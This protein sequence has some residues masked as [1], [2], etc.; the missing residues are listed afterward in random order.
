VFGLLTFTTFGTWLPGPA[1]GWIDAG[2]A[3]TGH[4]WPEPNEAISAVRRRSLR[5]PA[6]RLDRAG[7]AAVLAD[8]PR[9]AQLRSFTLQ[10]G[11]A[12]PDHAHILL[13]VD[14]DREIPRLVQLTKGA[15]SRALSVADGDSIARSTQGEALKH[16]KWWTRQYSFLGLA[17]AGAL[18]AL[19]EALHAAH[20]GTEAD[21]WIGHRA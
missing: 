13:E 10:L 9:I 20:Q 4:G 11:I 2:H 16:H 5:W 14:A 12:A 1:R 8:L 17:D 7:R 19:R 15:L 3:W 6:V 21:I 18:P